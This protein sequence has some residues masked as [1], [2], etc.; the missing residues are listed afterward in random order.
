[1]KDFMIYS[2]SLTAAIALSQAIQWQFEGLNKWVLT[3]SLI[4]IATG[5]ISLVTYL[6]PTDDDDLEVKKK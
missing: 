1:M 4:V 3:I 2:L 6:D 5:F